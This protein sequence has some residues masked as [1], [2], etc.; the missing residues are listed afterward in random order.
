MMEN[1]LD[2]VFITGGE[3]LLDHRFPT[4]ITKFQKCSSI[5]V[6]PGL[7]VSENVLRKCLKPMGEN[8]NIELRI[9]AESTEQNFEFNRF[10]SYWVN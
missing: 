1:G 4:I 8:K 6:H 3:P 9:S 7:G 10:G 5:I 2:K